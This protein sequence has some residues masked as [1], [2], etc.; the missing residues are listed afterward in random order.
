MLAAAA[1]LRPSVAAVASLSPDENDQPFGGLGTVTAQAAVG[2]LRTPVLYAVAAGDGYVSVD[3]VRALFARTA[4]RDRQLVVAAANSGHG[5][6][7]VATAGSPVDV[8]VR[9][10]LSRTAFPVR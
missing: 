10:L 9:Q 7:L 5:W 6:D 3:Q 4:A 8:R 2:R 1:Q